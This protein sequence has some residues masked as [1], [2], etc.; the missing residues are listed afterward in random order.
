MFDVGV[1][2]Q[3][4]RP[5]LDGHAE[6]GQQVLVPQSVE[7]EALLQQLRHLRRRGAIWNGRRQVRLPS[8]VWRS[9]LFHRA[10]VPCALVGW[11]I[12]GVAGVTPVSI[13]WRVGDCEEEAAQGSNYGHHPTPPQSCPTRSRALDHRPAPVTLET[14]GRGGAAD[15]L[16]ASSRGST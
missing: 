14:A 8:S 4:R 16:H 13:R 2:H 10:T 15:A 11:S 12:Y 9:G 3:R 5:L 1:E 6:H 7:H